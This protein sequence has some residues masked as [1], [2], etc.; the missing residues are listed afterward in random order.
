MADQWVKLKVIG[1][2]KNNTPAFMREVDKDIVMY[3]AAFVAPDGLP[4][5]RDD[6]ER[7][8]EIRQTTDSTM[9]RR[10]LL[11]FLH[12][13]EIGVLSEELIPIP[14]EAVYSQELGEKASTDHPAK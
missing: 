7:S 8:F 9:Y 1:G 6:K 4:L 11:R 10:M 12:E 2:P 5:Q 3:Q 13:H 14:V